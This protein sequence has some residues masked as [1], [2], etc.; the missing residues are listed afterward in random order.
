MSREHVI[1][2]NLY[3]GP[4]N[5]AIVV[6]SHV[7][8]NNSFSMDE[9]YLRNK[10]TMWA[11]DCSVDARELFFS[12]VK[13]SIQRRH[14]IGWMEL[15]K[16]DLVNLY[17]PEGIDLGPKT[18]MEVTPDDWRRIYRVLDKTIRALIFHELGGILPPEYLI[19]HCVL[20][21]EAALLTLREK[22]DSSEC[23][24]KWNRDNEK[25]CFFGYGCIPHSYTSVWVLVFYKNIVFKSLVG[26]EKNFAG[27]KDPV[28]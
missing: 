12:K 24:L 25:T 2:K 10:L 7:E 6:P 19:R 14:A 8:C 3:S 4:I 16:M 5:N 13:R 20:L 22:L 27:P 1:A 28:D 17:T 23:V 21:D 9:E 15:E 11:A 18:R 26:T